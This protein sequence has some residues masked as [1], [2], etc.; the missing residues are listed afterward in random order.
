MI[1]IAWHAFQN[2]Q[3]IIRKEG[4][5]F[6]VQEQIIFYFKSSFENEGQCLG[7]FILTNICLLTGAILQL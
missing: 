5:G 3:A 7:F 1:L 2:Q 6:I 4:V